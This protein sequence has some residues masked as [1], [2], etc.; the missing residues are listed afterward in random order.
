MGTDPSFQM[1]IEDV[2]SIRGRGTVV[3]GHIESGT[4][5]V[6]DEVN[7]AGRTVKV[8]GIEAFRKALKEANAGEHVG[9]LLRD[10]ARDDVHPGDILT[11]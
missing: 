6:G 9:I 3:T 4:L 5:K 1:T 8:D 10:V 7:L 2:F 11:G